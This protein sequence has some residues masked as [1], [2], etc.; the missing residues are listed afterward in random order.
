[1]KSQAGGGV[2]LMNTSHLLDALRYI[3]GLS[4]TSVSAEIGTLIANVEVEDMATAT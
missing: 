3:T 4:M 2:V 1:M